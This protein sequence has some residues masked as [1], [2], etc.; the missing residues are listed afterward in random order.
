MTADTARLATAAT[1]L[2]DALDDAQ[3]EMACLPFSDEV[4]RRTWFYWPAPRRGVP[5]AAL[6]ARQRQLV[7][8]LISASVRLPTFAKVTAIMALE[9]VLG[10]IEGG[11]THRVRDPALYFTSFFGEPDGADPW[12]VRFEGHHVSIHATVV[13]GEIAPTPIFLGANPAEV[14]NAGRIVVRPLAEE[15]DLGRALLLALPGV[16]RRRATIDDT[17]PDDIV[18]SNAPSVDHDLGGGVPVSDLSGEAAELADRLVRLYVERTTTPVVNV[19]RD[20]IHFAWAGS[21]ERGQPHYYR[22]SGPRFLAE[23]DNTQN[24]A[25]HGHAVWRDPAGD[26]GDDLL[27]RHRA[28]DHRPTSQ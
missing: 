6:D 23:Y 18:T 13:G 25:N 19:R 21:R 16:H 24:D 10:E 20:E 3:R 7:H 14:V 8:R 5:L 1:D 22:L 17:A 9:E 4:E 26:F 11:G 12:G 2:I 27:R 28:E 15:E